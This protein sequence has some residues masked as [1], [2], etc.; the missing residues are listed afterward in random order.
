LSTSTDRGERRTEIRLIEPADAE[1]IADHRIRDAV[2][3]TPWEPAQPASFYTV[4]GQAQRIGQ[5]LAAHRTGTV[6][7]GVVLSDGV[8]VGQVTVSMIVGEPF[9]SGWVGYWITGAHQNQGHAGR[10]V[11]MVLRVMAGELGLHR[12]EASTR[13]ENVASQSVLRRNGFTPCGIAHSRVF[14]DGAWR[15]EILWENVLDRT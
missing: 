3:F 13:L 11:G 2:A 1:V 5:L 7:P 6:W 10:A 12:A 15:D 14:L 9:R 8:V 4:D